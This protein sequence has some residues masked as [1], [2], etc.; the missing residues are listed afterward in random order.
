MCDE[1]QSDEDLAGK[2][3]DELNRFANELG[4]FRVRASRVDRDQLLFEAGWAAVPQNPLQTA[5]VAARTLRRWQLAT[6]SSSTAAVLLCALLL[7]VLA[8]RRSSDGPLAK[9]TNGSL[10]NV[11]SMS[12]SKSSIEV[13]QTVPDKKSIDRDGTSRDSELST[14][15]AGR[16]VEVSRFQAMQLALVRSI[17][18]KF[19]DAEIWPGR[20]TTTAS[21]FDQTSLRE[22][23]LRPYS[24][25]KGE[26]SQRMIDALT[27]ESRL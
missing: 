21:G 14:A 11:R 27:E 25:M 1:K 13:R 5:V 18:S 26:N 4:L 9:T 6:L 3:P 23:P 15:V 7:M 8:D 24:L 19:D 10:Q 2:L 17:D 12:G 16:R 20:V 22:E